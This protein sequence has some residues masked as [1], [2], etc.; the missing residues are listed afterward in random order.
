MVC[1]EKDCFFMQYMLKRSSPEEFLRL[2][3][4]WLNVNTYEECITCSNCRRRSCL[5]DECPDE[6]VYHRRM[7]GKIW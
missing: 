5:G 7:K 2:H 1:N 6:K 3:N 4:E